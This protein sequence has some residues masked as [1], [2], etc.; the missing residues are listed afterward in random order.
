MDGTPTPFLQPNPFE[1][2]FNRLFGALIDWGI[3]LRHNYLV[4]VQGRKSG[5]IYSTPVDVMDF[6]GK[7]YLVVPQGETQWVRNAYVSGEV[8]LKRGRSGQRYALR[9]LDD[10]EKPEILK[11]YLNRYKTTV[12]RYFSVP[13][14]APAEAFSDIAPRYPVFEL[15]PTIVTLF[16]APLQSAL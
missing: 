15:S 1:R 2:L 14:G 7:R 9:T 10:R 8:W 13:A 16:P 6:K 11:E 3:G 4:Q 12:Q 5:R